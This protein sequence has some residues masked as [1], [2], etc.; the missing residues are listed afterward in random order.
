MSAPVFSPSLLSQWERWY[1]SEQGQPQLL[2]SGSHPILF[3]ESLRFI[4]PHSILY[5]H[6]V[7]LYQVLVFGSLCILISFTHFWKNYTQQNGIATLETA[8]QFMI[9]LNI[10]W[11]ATPRL[12]IYPRQRKTYDHTK[13]CLWM[14][15]A[16]FFITVKTW[17]WCKCP[18]SSEWIKK[19]WYI[20][21]VGYYS[22]IKRQDLL[23]ST[24]ALMNLK[25]FAK[26]KKTDSET[27]TLHDSTCM[28]F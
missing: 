6:S 17:K 16:A 5:L 24:T 14:F 8:W 20:H 10:Q 12:G 22:V 23:V 13:T 19:Q 7:P 28:T 1:F 27:D 15:T 4:Y 9:N 25:C 21:A 26:W 2:F 11:S 3:L 18:L